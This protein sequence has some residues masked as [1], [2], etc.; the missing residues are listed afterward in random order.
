MQSVNFALLNFDNIEKSKDTFDERMVEPL[1]TLFKDKF[2]LDACFIALVIEDTYELVIGK[3]SV[4]K[5]CEQFVKIYHLGKTGYDKLFKNYDEDLICDHANSILDGESIL[6]YGVFRDDGTLDGIVGFADFHNREREWTKEE[7]NSL[8][9]LGKTLRLAVLYE[10]IKLQSK[11]QLSRLRNEFK[12]QINIITSATSD[13][14]SIFL[15][16]YDTLVQT[17]YYTNGRYKTVLDIATRELYYPKSTKLAVYASVYKDDR[18][19]VLEAMDINNVK[20]RLA[21]D[22]I[23]TVNYRRYIEDELDYAAFRF[24]QIE[25]NHK[26]FIVLSIKEI[27]EPREED[28]KESNYDDLTGL[29]TKEEFMRRCEEKIV[30]S[31]DLSSLHMVA[32]DVDKITQYNAYFGIQAGNVLLKQISSI[33]KTLTERMEAIYCRLGAD[34]FAVLIEG[35]MTEIEE[36]IKDIKSNTKF[37]NPRFFVNLSFGIVS[38]E[39]KHTPVAAIIDRALSASKTAKYKFDKLYGI[40]DDTIVKQRRADKEILDKMENAVENHKIIPYYQPVYDLNDNKI[41]SIEEFARWIDGENIIE[42]NKFIEVFTT[43]G[44]NYRMD[45]SVWEDCIKYLKYRIQNKLTPYSISLNISDEFITYDELADT[46][47]KLVKRYNVNPNLIN[48]EIKEYAF[49]QSH[50]EAARVIKKLKEI[51]FNIILDNFKAAISLLNDDLFNCIKIDLQKFD[52][53]KNN[54]KIILK[55]ILDLSKDLNVKVVATKVEDKKTVDF[56]KE[57]NVKYAQGYYFSKALSEEDLNNM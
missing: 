57:N 6:H 56:L 37:F 7:K 34:R 44:Y 15:I 51:G 33:L 5:D 1:L 53:N 23:Y 3:N 54:D 20:A 24:T 27:A 21:A 17:L 31:K 39:D 35:E 50:D 30:L 55:S 38:I 18:K 8:V 11:Q 48:I 26:R 2:K 29:F 9:K 19:R 45:V 47:N 25:I 14:S 13:Y 28:V 36:L 43:T 52:L 49:E 40:Y 4:N 32:F 16:D 12:D 22:G 10:K 42:Y 46:L 41:V